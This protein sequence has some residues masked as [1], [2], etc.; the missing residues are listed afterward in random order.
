MTPRTGRVGA[1]VAEVRFSWKQRLRW[2]LEVRVSTY[3]GRRRKQTG[4]RAAGSAV[5]AQRQEPWG[6]HVDP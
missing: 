4:E 1:C 2:K 3:G 5:E 6:P